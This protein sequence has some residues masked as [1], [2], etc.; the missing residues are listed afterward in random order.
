MLSSAP[1]LP[2]EAFFPPAFSPCFLNSPQSLVSSLLYLLPVILLLL[3]SLSRT[4]IVFSP[5]FPRCF[6][7]CQSYSPR[8]LSDSFPINILCALSP[9][10]VKHPHG[11]SSCP[12]PQCLPGLLPPFSLPSTILASFLFIFFPSLY[13]VPLPTSIFF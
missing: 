7:E 2:R 4:L 8:H 10:H 3:L 1:P 12:R 9:E 5:Y 13:T 6:L 11:V